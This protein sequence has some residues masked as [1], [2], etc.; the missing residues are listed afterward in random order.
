MERLKL[1]LPINVYGSDPVRQFL[2]QLSR[3][4]CDQQ[5]IADLGKA[6]ES[7]GYRREASTALVT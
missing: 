7:A 3:E 4:R 1:K 5:A 2:G 6:L